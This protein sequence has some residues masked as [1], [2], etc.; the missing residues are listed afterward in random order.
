[1]FKVKHSLEVDPYNWRVLLEAFRGLS[2]QER[3][4]VLTTLKGRVKRLEHHVNNHLEGQPKESW[5]LVEELEEELDG[6]SREIPAEFI[7]LPRRL[8]NSVLHTYRYDDLVGTLEQVH[9]TMSRAERVASTY[10]IKAGDSVEEEGVDEVE[11][12]LDEEIKVEDIGEETNCWKRIDLLVTRICQARGGYA[13][14]T[15]TIYDIMAYILEGNRFVKTKQR[16][17]DISLALYHK[18]Y[19]GSKK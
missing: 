15:Q 14:S 10:P 12:V 13:N 18:F 2:L 8:L 11:V 17:R 19:R 16:Q 9:E 1:L 3:D 6:N 5:K 7:H 4:Q